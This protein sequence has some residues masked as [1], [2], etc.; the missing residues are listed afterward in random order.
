MKTT[1]AEIA[2][3]A[4]AALR[5]DVPLSTLHLATDYQARSRKAAMTV[6]Q[7]AATIL[8]VGLL[9]NLIVVAEAD[10]TFG[11]C[12]GGRRLAALQYLL[13]Q[14]KI[15]NDFLVSVRII[16]KEHAHHAS[17]IE[18][19]AREDMHTVDLIVAYDRLHQDQNMSAEAIAA[20]H[21]ASVLSVKKLLALANVAPDLL[22]L[23][24]HDDKKMSFE[25]LQALAG[26]GDHERQRSAWKACRT[27]HPGSIPRSIR[28]MLAQ[29]EMSATAPIAR[30]LTIAG[31]EKAGGIVRR[32]LFTEGNQGV[33]LSD[34]IQADTLAI[35]KMKRSKLA[36]AVSGEGW[37][38]V[39]FLTRF[40]W[41]D[42][43][44]Y[45]QLKET[46]REPTKSE[47]AQLRKLNDAHRA[48]QEKLNALKEDDADEGDEDAILAKLEDLEN[49]IEVIENELQEF[50][51]KHKQVAGTILTLDDSGNLTAKRGLIR[52][53]DRD[54]AQ[55]L[56]CGTST[57]N[58]D[59]G[60]ADLPGPLTRP[61]HSQAL[62]ARLQAQHAL[63]VQAE[64]AQ[65]PRLAVCLHLIQL[66]EQVTNHI[67]YLSPAWN[68]F[69][70]HAHSARHG[71]QSVDD[72]IAESPAAQHLDARQAELL[73]GLPEEPQ[74]LLDHL[75]AYTDD[76][77]MALMGLLLA[78]T[79]PA[80]TGEGGQINHVR[81]VHSLTDA[82]MTRWWSPTVASY[83]GSVS[84]DQIAKVVTEA[85]GTDSAAPLTNMK[86]GEA[87]TTAEQLL[88]G[89]G[90]LPELMRK[91]AQV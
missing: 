8:A 30:Y 18:N 21:G 84:K 15:G 66:V 32:D 50:N 45:G 79:M 40:T 57:A 23:Y 25:A 80:S 28:E 1:T 88:A 51:P 74:A 29:S 71:F 14:G 64:L 2:A 22:D 52:R 43:R 73:V 91:P 54:A 67:S 3:I 86:K 77:L 47:A 46:A 60:A 35:E 69:P 4:D 89:R 5:Q 56:I 39:E 37:A 53:E 63:G 68:I 44:Q 31:Y 33:F 24:R 65:R 10:G 17:L 85:V 34:P 81:T 58:R 16:A 87:A 82:D 83:L 42:S 38:W 72:L 62:T 59:G 75:L 36:A 78:L 48:E 7:L 41:D 55:A 13:E 12:A 19:V 6:E 9:N 76:Q 70:M 11:V 61:V 26:V 27:N 49:Q 90:W 20:A